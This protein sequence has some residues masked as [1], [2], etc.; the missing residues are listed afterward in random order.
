MSFSPAEVR[1]GMLLPHTLWLFSIRI[2]IVNIV[3]VEA[4]VSVEGDQ[5]IGEYAAQREKQYY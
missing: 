5:N 4:K 2:I 3:V 1:R